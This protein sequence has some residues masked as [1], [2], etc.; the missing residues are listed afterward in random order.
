[1][2][3]TLGLTLCA[4]FLLAFGT[5]A[6]AVNELLAPMGEQGATQWSHLVKPSLRN[7][8]QFDDN[9]TTSKPKDEAWGNLFGPKVSFRLPYE[10][11]YVGG[12]VEYVSRYYGGSRIGNHKG[13]DDAF[14]NIVLKHDVSDRL[15][16]G[17]KQYFAYQ[18]QPNTV[19]PGV[20]DQEQDK[21]TLDDEADYAL[22]VNNVGVD[23]RFN[24]W[25]SVAG[26]Y[27]LELLEFD[28]A[29]NLVTSSLNLAQH[30]VGFDVNYRLWQDT[31]FGV[32]Y[33]FTK[34]D[35]EVVDK[36]FTSH[37]VSGVLR[38]NIAT[39]VILKARVG[40]EYRSP[41]Q[42]KFIVFDTQRIVVNNTGGTVDGSV[43]DIPGSDI[44]PFANNKNR[45]NEPYVEVDMTYLFTKATQ[46]KVGYK[47]K[48][49]NSEQPAFFD[50]KAQG[51]YGSLVHKLTRKTQLLF[52]GSQEKFTYRNNRVFETVTPLDE[53]LFKFG[54]LLSQQL[55]PWLFLELGYRYV[56]MDS[57]FSFFAT[58]DREDGSVTSVMRANSDY[59]RNRVF[60]GVL[61]T[62]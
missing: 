41:V 10:K 30:K 6:Y 20:P 35:Y 45:S 5:A 48:L 32:G 33:R 19:K 26:T 18:Q 25:L 28:S 16:V 37:L 40:Y 34:G 43:N 24:K 27:D 12:D 60:S 55:K 39:D 47:L 59:T 49:E 31:L 62:F 58:D 23:Y 46:L 7:Q 57:D 8:L 61:M 44:T 53:N 54:F 21:I 13:D 56:D 15:S 36:D 14:V 9:V 42:K 51:V 17:V 1:M 38:H 2:K 29:N 11:S 4:S 3:R 22:Y 52:F 50:R